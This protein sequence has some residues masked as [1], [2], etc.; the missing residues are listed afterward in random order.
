MNLIKIAAIV[1]IWSGFIYGC[2]STEKYEASKNNAYS[3]QSE[4]AQLEERL[5]ETEEQL[6]LE[7]AARESMEADAANLESEK[8]ELV[9]QNNLLLF[10]SKSQNETIS[11]I[12][13]EK[14][15]AIKEKR[16]Y[17]WRTEK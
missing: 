13:K 12:M 3:L 1:I 16:R 7:K 4:K 9:R 11:E 14:L 2:V 15:N 5:L 10:T 6:T 8:A 17:H